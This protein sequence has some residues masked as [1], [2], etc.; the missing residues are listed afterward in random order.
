[1]QKLSIDGGFSCPNRDGTIGTGGCSFCNNHAFVPE[2]CRRE[3]GITRQIEEGI[4]FFERKYSGQ[5]YLAYFQ[6]YSG[7]H[8]P[9]EVL[10]ERYEEALAH[11][12]VIGIVIATRP[13]TVTCETLDYLGTLARE[14]YVCIEFGVESTRDDVLA[15]INRGHG[16]AEAEIA[17]RESARR[18]IFTGAHLILGLPGESRREMVEGA[19]QVSRW[20][21]HLLKLHQLQVVEGTRM[22]EEY[23]ARPG[24][25]PL[26]A[27]DEYLDLVVDIV[28]HIRPD[29]YLER[30]VNQTP[31]GLLI[32]P[33]W[34]VKNFEFAMMLERRLKERGTWQGKYYEDK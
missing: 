13:D 11:P 12:R 18:G 17:C 26:H 19:V 28:E 8:A 31:A 24:D 21:V 27:L 23:R 5:K 2:Y 14:R 30:F 20:P 34:G 22:A 1:M 32:A 9:L 25:F 7:T 33:R 6:A 10:R 4:R 16:V 3:S 29:L 15:R